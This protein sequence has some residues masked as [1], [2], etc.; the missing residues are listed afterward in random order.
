MNR[1]GSLLVLAA[2]SAA[3]ATSASA[4]LPGIP[5]GPVETGLGLN[6]SADYGKPNDEAGGGSAYGLTAGLGFSRF[7]FSAS[8]GG[9]KPD[10]YPSTE[11]AMAGRLGMKLFG[12]GLN[13]VTVGAQVGV[14]SVAFEV[15]P[16]TSDRL[17]VIMPAA[18]IKVSPPLFPLKP[19]GQVYYVTG[20]D[21]EEEVRFAIGANFNLLLGLGVHAGYD[22]GDGGNALGV[23][24]H[25]PFPGPGLGLPGLP[26]M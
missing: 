8:V 24:V 20:S 10:G 21:V 25:I 5:Y 23:G 2:M 6:V 16:G 26:G 15:I 14:S 4:Q 13:P 7:G 1:T 22:F 18:F 19:W 9:V 3:V 11:I 12:G 17:T